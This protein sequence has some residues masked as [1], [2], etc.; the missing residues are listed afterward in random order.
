[1][2]REREP[3]R[4]LDIVDEPR[5]PGHPAHG[6]DRRAPGRDA[7]VG[8]ARGCREDVVEV[9]HRLA[10]AHEDRVRDW[11]E[12]TKVERLVEDLGRGEIPAKAHSPGRA[13]RARE[14]AAGLGGEAE[15]ATTVAVAHQHGLHRVAVVR[16]MQRLHRS[17]LR[18]PLGHDLD[19]RERHG[20]RERRPQRE[21]AA[22][23]SRRSRT[24]RAPST[25]TPVARGTRARPPPAASLRG[26]RCPPIERSGVEA[27][28]TGRDRAP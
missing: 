17:V 24:H 8:Q 1:M 5:Q 15:R 13:E 6:G 26:A 27:A 22:T 28:W 7:E 12:S 4:R 23:S 19:R 2:E 25:P 20:L 3:N 16:A 11:L 18:S 21:R 9:E 10:H 14:R